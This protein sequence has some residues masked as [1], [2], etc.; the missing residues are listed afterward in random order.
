MKF[1]VTKP[2]G[3]EVEVKLHW[4]TKDKLK[5]AALWT[6]SVVAL[7]GAFVYI[8]NDKKDEPEE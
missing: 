1:I 6:T 4:E 5:R 2:Y 3:N 7:A 8:Y